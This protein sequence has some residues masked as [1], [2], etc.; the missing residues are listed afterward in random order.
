[1]PDG[2]LV[3]TSHAWAGMVCL[4]RNRTAYAGPVPGRPGMFA[5]LAYHGNGVAMG[6]YSGRAL[7]HLAL[8][9][10]AE[11]PS[12]FQRPMARFP[13]GRARRLLMPPIYLIG[14]LKDR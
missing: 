6:T 3:D 9:D 11:I 7:A 5:A 13:L 14:Q 1:L 2:R 8:D 12:V 4:S 10:G